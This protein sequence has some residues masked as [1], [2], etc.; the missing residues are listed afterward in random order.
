MKWLLALLHFRGG[1]QFNE[2]VRSTTL[3]FRGLL[4]FIEV[5][6]R[7]MLELSKVGG[8]TGLNTMK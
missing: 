1:L 7:G 2:V 5:L 4:N 8:S 3:N 6:D